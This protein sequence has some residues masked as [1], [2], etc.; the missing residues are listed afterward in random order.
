MLRATELKT[1][2]MTE[3]L[4]IH[5]LHPRFSWQLAGTGRHQ[6]AYRIRVISADGGKGWDSGRVDSAACTGIR[7]EGKALFSRERLRWGLRDTLHSWSC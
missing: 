6:T 4:G 2:Y 5:S 3:P 1:E 7:F